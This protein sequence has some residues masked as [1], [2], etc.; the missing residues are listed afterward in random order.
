MSVV[1]GN[2]GNTEVIFVKRGEKG[3][4]YEERV[5]SVFKAGFLDTFLLPLEKDKKVLLVGIGKENVK[6][7][8]TS[9]EI[10]AK[11]CK[12]L[13]KYEIS[14]YSFNVEN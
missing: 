1:L 9:M 11:A 10:S 2:V 4:P 6:E 3:Y 13:K 5:S 12:A 8:T 7:P 14:E